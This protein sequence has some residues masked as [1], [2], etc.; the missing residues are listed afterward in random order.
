MQKITKLLNAHRPG[1]AFLA[2]WLER[3]GVSRELQHSYL[4]SGWLEPLGQGAFRRTGD[5]DLARGCRNF[6]RSG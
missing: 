2:G 6:A 5:D 3:R 4:R 1:T